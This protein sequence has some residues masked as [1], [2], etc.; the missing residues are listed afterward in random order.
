MNK[1][2]PTGKE[3][4]CGVAWYSVPNPPGSDHWL[5][6]NTSVHRLH[7]LPES[8]SLPLL[9]GF[10]T[11]ESHSTPTCKPEISLEPSS[12]LT[13]LHPVLCLQDH[14]SPL[15]HNASC[16]SVQSLNIHW[17]DWCWNSYTLAIWWEELTHWKR[18]WCWERLKAG[19]EGDHRGWDGWMASPTQWTWVWVNSRSWWWTG[20]PDVLQ[21]IGSQRFG[22]NWV[23]E[24][25]WTESNY[26]V[27]F[28]V[29]MYGC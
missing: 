15:Q 20:R 21:S 19:G 8:Y 13:P 22:N 16:S 27:T 4:R 26:I 24:L 6:L 1:M 2:C 25:N 28:P 17:K 11:S 5:P 9:L 3:S 12:S 7:P 14:H 29:V 10:L 18:L 23:T